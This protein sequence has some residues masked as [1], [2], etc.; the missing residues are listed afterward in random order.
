MPEVRECVGVGEGV[1][2]ASRCNTVGS[3]T[4]G[5]EVPRSRHH[6]NSSSACVQCKP[7][8]GPRDLVR[9]VG[10]GQELGH[11]HADLGLQ[12]HLRRTRTPQRA[13][14]RPRCAAYTKTHDGPWH[15]ASP[16]PL[17]PG[18]LPLMRARAAYRFNGQ[19][20]PNADP[21]D[22]DEK[23]NTQGTPTTST[24]DTAWS[25]VHLPNCTG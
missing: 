11:G 4:T 24:T 21:D 23:M 10:A 6:L 19:Q 16:P 20:V 1:V 17:H 8:R 25:A 3:R 18:P 15:R 14:S 5:Q 9:G 13:T 7:Y 12:H 22:R 2:G